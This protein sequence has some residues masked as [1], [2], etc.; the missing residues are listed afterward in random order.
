MQAKK[1]EIEK[2]HTAIQELLTELNRNELTILHS[3]FGRVKDHFVELFGRITD[4]AGLADMTLTM[5]DDGSDSVGSVNVEVSFPVQGG[6]KPARSKRL[7]EL[8][9]GQ[10]TV[11]ALCFLLS[12]HKAVDTQSNFFILDEVDAALDPNYRAAIA[13]ALFDESVK[14]V[15]FLFTSFRPEF[16]AVATKHWLV[17][18]A[19]GT[20][21]VS[22]V[23]IATA[24]GL[25]NGDDSVAIG[26][27]AVAEEQQSVLLRE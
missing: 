27:E 19:N 5:A 23:D 8:S 10:R 26:E 18:M 1:T 12:L 16:C 13:E 2:S 6:E 17:S 15:Q 22:A 3:A 14:G 24:M 9:G 11:V 20:S 7:N 4:G 21:K 25:V